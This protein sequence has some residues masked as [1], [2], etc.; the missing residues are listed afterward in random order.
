MTLFEIDFSD[1]FK[2]AKDYKYFAAAIPKCLFLRSTTDMRDN[3]TDQSAREVEYR[4]MVLDRYDRIRVVF[5]LDWFPK[6]SP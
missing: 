6:R 4:L 3:I 5:N 2:K 1:I